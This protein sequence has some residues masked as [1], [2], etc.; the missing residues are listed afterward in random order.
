MKI[1]K[2]INRYRFLFIL[3]ISVICA[4]N[5]KWGGQRWKEIIAFDGK[6]YYAYL[7]AVFVYHDLQLTFLDSIE[8]K[9]SKPNT[10]FEIRVVT[11]HGSIDK[12]FCGT[13]F[14]QLPFFIVAHL[15]TKL[16]GGI[17][18]GYSFIYQIFISL[19]GIIYALIGLFFLQKILRK[20][21]FSESIITIVIFIIFFGTQLFYYSIFDP[22]YSHVYSF[23]I[24][25][26]FIFMLKK[27]IDNQ[28]DKD[29]IL[30]GALLAI[31]ILIRP[32]NGL[33]IFI[34][35]FLAGSRETTISVIKN[36]FK[37]KTS[38]VLAAALFI[39]ITSIQFI[40]YYLQ[41]GK[42]FIDSYVVE[43]FLW[44]RPEIINILFS[45]KK[46]LFIYTPLTFIALA[47]LIPLYHKSNYSF[48]WFIIFFL[49]ITYVF[50]C[51]WMW[52]YG[53]SFSARPYTEFLS[54]FAILL[55]FLL[56]RIIKMFNRFL[57]YSLILFCV[58]LCQVQIYQF[59]YYIIH[60]EEMDKEH[61]WRVFMRIDQIIKQENPN[62]DMLKK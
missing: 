51:W 59:R 16:T 39:L 49:T 34:F 56:L 9:Y 18:D 44:Y 12:Y 25:T 52:W 58:I 47:G 36:I 40:F 61:Y 11:P 45:Y 22:S 60:W 28:N 31:I 8:E 23:A 54:L 55:A 32:V 41:T 4:S 57:I 38:F 10:H 33:I 17:A 62:S 26:A 1:I 29:L 7:P 35:P 43:S 2:Y 20:Y 3:L 5:V 27:Y 21:S 37:H 13:A 24:I 6:G 50:S 30:L 53:G 14:T 42:L 15:L 46:G 19:A 48:W